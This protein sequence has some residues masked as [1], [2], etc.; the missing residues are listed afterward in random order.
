LIWILALI[1]R[2][3]NSRTVAFSPNKR[4]ALRGQGGVRSSKGSIRCSHAGKVGGSP[5]AMAHSTPGGSAM[6]ERRR[7]QRSEQ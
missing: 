1:S 7:R 2:V 5:R 3:I 4:A 6:L